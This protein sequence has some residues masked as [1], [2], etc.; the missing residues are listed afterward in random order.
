MS[1]RT[2]VIPLQK[3]TEEH[4]R[5]RVK[6]SYYSLWCWVEHITYNMHWW[7]TNP[8][9]HW[10]VVLLQREHPS[11]YWWIETLTY[12]LMMRISHNQ[13]VTCAI[14]FELEE[15]KR[16]ADWI[17]LKSWF[18]NPSKASFTNLSPQATSLK[19]QPWSQA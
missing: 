2:S 18:I 1:W 5:K 14:K 6:N 12:S 16:R 4:F 9:C 17:K 11:A 15:V 10:V 3:C 19:S 13:L 7:D 8:K